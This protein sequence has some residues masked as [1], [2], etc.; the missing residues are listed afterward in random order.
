MLGN[1]VSVPGFV[2][3]F[4][5]HCLDEVFC[6]YWVHGIVFLFVGLWCPPNA[7]GRSTTRVVTRSW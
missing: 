6:K 3:A 2:L 4:E 7:I 5:L 1:E